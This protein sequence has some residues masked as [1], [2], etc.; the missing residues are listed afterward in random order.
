MVKV[1]DIEHNRRERENEW[2]NKLQSEAKTGGH[3]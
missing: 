3:G 1:F 2:D